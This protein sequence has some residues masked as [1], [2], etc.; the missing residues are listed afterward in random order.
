M[1][2]HSG[3]QDT[4]EGTKC[5]VA[6]RVTVAVVERLEVVDVE[7]EHGQRFLRPSTSSSQ[8]VLQCLV[9]GAA[10][11]ETGPGIGAG[12]AL[13]GNEQTSVG[14]GQGC[15]L[16]DPGHDRA[17]AERQPIRRSPMKMDR[18]DHLAEGQQRD[19]RERAGHGRVDR[20]ADAESIGQIARDVQAAAPDA[21]TAAQL[22]Q[23]DNFRSDGPDGPFRNG[24]ILGP[25]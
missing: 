8:R 18:A 25:V 4:G 14:D 11:G 5:L 24:P 7:H 22:A 6:G 12:H 21:G 3:A 2:A 20:T 13:E 23:R 17:H 1:A 16:S 10:V 9:E 15:V 19:A